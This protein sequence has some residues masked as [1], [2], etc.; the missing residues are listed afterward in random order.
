MP[1]RGEDDERRPWEETGSPAACPSPTT[2]PKACHVSW[3]SP[4]TCPSPTMPGPA[5]TSA[6]RGVEGER[7]AGYGRRLG[8][9]PLA[10]RRARRP[11]PA[12]SV[13]ARRPRSLELAG[14]LPLANHA[15]TGV[16]VG[17]ERRGGGEGH[18]RRGSRRRMPNCHS[19][20]RGGRERGEEGF[21]FFLDSRVFSVNFGHPHKL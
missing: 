9:R 17:G 12:L 18:Q 15:Q 19:R 3:S 2:P 8:H 21:I 10:P 16:D 5:S 13:G 20:E 6:E 4:A 1:T 14:C 11:E 7:G